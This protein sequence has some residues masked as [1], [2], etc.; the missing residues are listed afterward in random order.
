MGNGAAIRSIEID[1]NNYNLNNL[2]DHINS[3]LDAANV[4]SSTYKLQIYSLTI[5]SENTSK[6]YFS[7]NQ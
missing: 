4:I 7:N 3:K 6:I 2:I 5:P 1:I